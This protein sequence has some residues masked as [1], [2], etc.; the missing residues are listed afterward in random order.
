VSGD[1]FYVPDNKLSV[2]SHN[3][4]PQHE[5]PSA[6]L[7]HNGAWIAGQQNPNQFIQVC[8]FDIFV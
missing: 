4:N 3:P 5:A 1:R 2:S 8:L 7:A 6:R